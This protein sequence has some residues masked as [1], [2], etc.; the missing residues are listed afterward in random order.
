MIEVITKLVCSAFSFNS[1]QSGQIA[2]AYVAVIMNNFKVKTFEPNYFCEMQIGVCKKKHYEFL[3]PKVEAKR[4][5]EDKPDFIKDNNY[6]NQLYKEIKDDEEAGVERETILLYH[7]SDL[8]FNLN[9]Q[10]GSSNTCDSLVCCTSSSGEPKND[11]QTAG[12]WGDYNCDSNPLSLRQ[13]KY[14]VN[15]TGRPNFVLWTGDS[16]DHGVYKD[17]RVTTNATVE[18]TNFFNTHSPKAI[19]FP[20]HGNHEFNPMNLQNFKQE[21]DPVVSIL[22]STWKEWMTED[23]YQEY[24]EK[25]YFS[26]NVTDHPKSNDEFDKKMEGTRL[27]A[28]N[29]QN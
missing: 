15:M 5:L 11:E 26:Y 27:I 2:D 28:L 18:I 13:L 8:H 25:S 20:I 14:T 10:E 29:T 16:N 7:V 22:A 9:Y 6:I 3:D 24:L 1:E 23:V 21:P 12:K 19:I 17:P 4:I